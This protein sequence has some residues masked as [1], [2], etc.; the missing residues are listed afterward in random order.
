MKK[1]V[2]IFLASVLLS[3]NFFAFD[4]SVMQRYFEIGT[5]VSIMG[6]NNVI[7]L[8]DFFTENVVIDLP[9]ISDDTTE[10]GFVIN[11]V[12][13]IPNIF[14]NL[15]L[16][17]KDIHIRTNLG[18]ETSF[19]I[20]LQ[21]DLIDILGKGGHLNEIGFGVGS[22]ID[23]FSYYNVEASFKIKKLAVTVSPSA[24][25]PLLHIEPK[26]VKNFNART[27]MNGTIQFDGD[28]TLLA[29]SR[30]NVNKLRIAIEDGTFDTLANDIAELFKGVGFDLGGSIGY[31][32]RPS[33]QIGGYAR[34]PVVPGRLNQL[35]EITTKIDGEYGIGGQNKKPDFIDPFA[36]PANIKTSATNFSLSR[37][38][39]FGANIV[40]K[41]FE[42]WLTIDAFAGA[43]MKF[44]V[45]EGS[46]YAEYRAAVTA[47]IYNIVSVSLATQYL[48][49]IFMH[50]IGLSL[51]ARVLEVQAAI[52]ASSPNF[53]K[54]FHG[55]GF[56]ARFGVLV[57]F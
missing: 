13:G 52:S 1:R 18:L 34:I 23:I 56:S 43:A 15:H 38:L 51:N 30:F 50:E 12:L 5:S 9:K 48:Q 26:M 4:A 11:T 31:C 27:T 3:A 21:K 14:M 41:P 47:N 17:Q 7:P 10:S 53:K 16:K 42:K 2:V 33:L 35:A 25:I 32:V 45:G 6:G 40:Y 49:K 44:P 37:P 22:Q 55:T 24:F 54:S 57:G 28:Y 39:R 36:D 19:A 8:T 46:W 20:V 29:Y